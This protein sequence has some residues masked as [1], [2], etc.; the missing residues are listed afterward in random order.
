MKA[1]VDF[2]A[3]P[4]IVK[5][6][7]ERID[8]A[9]FSW[10]TSMWPSLRHFWMLPR[11]KQNHLGQMP[12]G[13]EPLMEKPRACLRMVR[14]RVVDGQEIPVGW[15]VK[16][17]SV[18]HWDCLSWSLPSFLL[19]DFACQIPLTCSISSSWFWALPGVTMEAAALS[20]IL[21]DYEP[22]VGGKT[23]DWLVSYLLT[24]IIINNNNG[25]TLFYWSPPQYNTWQK[26]SSQIYI[27]RWN[28][29]GKKNFF[30]L[31]KIPRRR[32][33]LIL[34]LLPGND[35]ISSTPSLLK[36][37]SVKDVCWDANILLFWFP[38]NRPV[39]NCRDFA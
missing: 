11:E 32:L 12:T 18:S 1:V 38:L 35:P 28:D 22:K 31:V 30:L 20:T 33:L 9:S 16:S 6:I 27:I 26:K 13:A 2:V 37:G 10:Q 8:L 17:P 3:D 39:G 24:I 15:R 36:Y 29:L 14:S 23:R 25:I 7:R 34:S 19:L 4:M 5:Y 21:W